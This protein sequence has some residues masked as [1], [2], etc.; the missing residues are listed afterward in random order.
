MVG[1]NPQNEVEL[2][3]KEFAL[4]GA[5]SGAMSRV[6]AQ[7]LD[8]LKIR[9]QVLSLTELLEF[10]QIVLALPKVVKL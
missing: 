3:H 10:L 8:V 6:L 2:S 5:L 4:A 7:P 1:Y 9:F